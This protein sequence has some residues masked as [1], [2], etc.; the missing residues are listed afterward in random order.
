METTQRRPDR[1]PVL[2][3]VADVESRDTFRVFVVTGETGI[4]S[5]VA[6][7]V[8]CNDEIEAIAEVIKR[9]GWDSARVNLKAFREP[10]VSAEQLSGAKRFIAA[11]AE[12]QSRERQDEAHRN[13]DEAIAR[14]PRA[15]EG[16]AA[17][18]VGDLPPGVIPEPVPGGVP[19]VI[20][21]E[22]TEGDKPQPEP[23]KPEPK[24][25]A[26]HPHK[27]HGKKPHK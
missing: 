13:R 10:D 24:P 7:V 19:T 15:A 5:P 6:R 23:E 4:E 25:E 22:V 27:G 20:P 18:V 17:V 11:D 1:L 12:R 26:E 16:V 14:D 9:N 21:P 3:M 2:F 8:G